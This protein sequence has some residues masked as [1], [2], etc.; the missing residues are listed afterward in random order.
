MFSMKNY[1]LLLLLITV[2][3]SAQETKYNL[4]FDQ[5]ELGEDL[6]DDWIVWGEYKIEKD[7][8]HTQSGEY[9]AKISSGDN[10]N[11]FGSIAY[12]IPANYKGN[13][14]MLQGFIK[15][16]N[17]TN[18][19]AGLLLRVDGSSGSL[20]FNNM[21]SQ[22]L[23]GTND[24]KKY[25][26][27]VR[28][29]E[30]A[31]SIYVGGILTGN[32]TAWFDDFTLK[33]NGS[34]DVQTLKEKEIT[35]KPADLDSS[36]ADGSKFKIVN[37]SNIQE[38]RLYKLGKVWGFL[39]YHHPEIAKGNINWDD[40]LFKILP[41]INSENFDSKLV[42]WISG[43]GSL[44]EGKHKVPQ[45]NEVE[46]TPNYDWIQDKNF[47]S[48]ELSVELR[49]VL[50]SKREKSNYYFG[51]NASVK[52]PYFKNER[53]YLNMSWDDTGVKL[54]ALFRYWNMMEYFNPNNYLTDKDWEEV[55]KEYIPRFVNENSELDYKKNMLQLIGEVGDT[56]ANMWS[57][58]EALNKF[59]GA[60][61]LPV[62]VEFIEDRP[63][64]VKIA[65]S[66]ELQIQ[67]GDVITAINGVAIKEIINQ[68]LEFYPASNY[69][70]KLRDMARKLLH[71]NKDSL[72][73]SFQNKQGAF[74]ETIF[75]V[76]DWNNSEEVISSHKFISDDIGYIYPESLKRGEINDIMKKF[77]NTKGIILDL[78]C[79]PSDFIV[80]SMGNKVV[81]EPTKF[82]KFTNT[83]IENPGYFTF[84]NGSKVGTYLRKS[85]NG[86]L[87]ILINEETQSQ[88]EYTTMALRVAPE[89]VVIGSQ[90]AGADGN[91][92]RI[93]L[94]GGI[95]TM[96]SGIG[97]YYPDGTETQRV[98][99]V[100][101]IEIHPT[102]ESFRNGEDVLLNKAIEVI[103]QS[104]SETE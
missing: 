5:T 57:Y 101:D 66:S 80:F 20:D 72:E 70:T 62:V 97:V 90:T 14:L 74:K 92:S 24:W 102:I 86:K 83:S 99:I 79:Y 103:Q 84:R 4:N 35:Y 2:S 76:E 27:M 37:I 52:N 98:G 44:E 59:F 49:K 73:I 34:K 17:I 67:E 7:S 53:T 68:N 61:R 51:I 16:E 60:K 65:D 18:G 1:L 50:T 23:S 26:I 46:L 94:P 54:L 69:P 81:P 6:P 88:A 96:I 58:D 22:G 47:L 75:S 100:P 36:Y 45:A 43:I 56:H 12:K 10:G 85:Y 8:V 38:D 91:I 95:R 104:S 32:G 30:G 3:A 21:Q 55:L 71:T 19:F 25:K 9:S 63:V 64:V 31:K 87:T 82:V 89:A 11:T 42:E 41:A 93:N 78:R 33:I 29:P 15:T 77:E 13:S 48:E 39:K 40:E 28:F